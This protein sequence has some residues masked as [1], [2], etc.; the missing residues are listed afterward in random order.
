MD[1]LSIVPLAKRA[2][3]AKSISI[4]ENSRRAFKSMIV[5]KE[6]RADVMDYKL[7]LT[8]D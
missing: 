7:A 2:H 4:K 8:N 1:L 3:Q 6:V 5:L